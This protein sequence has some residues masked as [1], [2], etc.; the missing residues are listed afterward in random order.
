MNQGFM[1]EQKKSNTSEGIPY[2][3]INGQKI[4]ARDEHAIEEAFKKVARLRDQLLASY[5]KYF[6]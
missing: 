1:I 5:E 4:N 3:M 2:V 6:K